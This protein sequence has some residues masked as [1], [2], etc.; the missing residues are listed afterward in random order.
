MFE[1]FKLR[2]WKCQVKNASP[3]RMTFEITR[4]SSK[5]TKEF[6]KTNEFLFISLLFCFSLLFFSLVFCFIF[7]CFVLFDYLSFVQT[8]DR[9]N[10]H[11]FCNSSSDIFYH[12]ITSIILSSLRFIRQNS[13]FPFLSFH[14]ATPTH[15]SE[16]K[17]FCCLQVC[18]NY[19][20]RK[21]LPLLSCLLFDVSCLNRLYGH[22]TCHF[23]CF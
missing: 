11:L 16:K 12:S 22:N 9:N 19:A 18:S 5:K 4:L 3:D 20:S 10:P 23:N 8:F 2:W 13:L 1:T 21:V 17:C 14:T 6:S 7:F 15:T